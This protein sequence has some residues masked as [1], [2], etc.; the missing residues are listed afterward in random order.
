MKQ[1]LL[2]SFLFAAFT[3]SA[4]DSIPPDT[5]EQHKAVKKQWRYSD[6]T[7][8]WSV[9]LSGGMGYAFRILESRRYAELLACRAACESAIYTPAAGVNVIY[10]LHKNLDVIS[11]ISY[12][13]TGFD[14]SEERQLNDTLEFEFIVACDVDRIVDPERGYIGAGFCDPRYGYGISGLHPDQGTLKINMRYHYLDI[15]LL[16]RA[17]V[18]QK[19][20]RAFVLAGASYNVLFRYYQRIAVENNGVEFSIYEPDPEPH[21][22]A[23]HRRFN[24]SAL[25]GAGMSYRINRSLSL[26]VQAMGRYQLLSVFRKEWKDYNER[27]YRLGA[28]V[29]LE[30]FF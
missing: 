24:L 4:Q 8:R 1:L 22:Y 19:R 28:D 2:L 10:K 9:G 17:N 30:Y 5:L 18:G 23:I 12:F 15:P 7:N 3:L 27:H 16:L 25:A 20:F 26:G 14:L 13:Q 11:G 6:D 21:Y 29:S